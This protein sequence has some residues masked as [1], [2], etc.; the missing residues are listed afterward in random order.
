MEIERN[1]SDTCLYLENLVNITYTVG[2]LTGRSAE[3][4]FSLNDHFELMPF[5]LV[6][7]I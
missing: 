1:N 4:S 2:S 6:D 7:Y 5:I 3:G